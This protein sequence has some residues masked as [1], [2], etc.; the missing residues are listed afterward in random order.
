MAV[1]H[2]K[3][4]IGARWL[5]NC[6]WF[7]FLFEVAASVVA[8]GGGHFKA[9]F[10]ADFEADLAFLQQCVGLMVAR[11]LLLLGMVYLGFKTGQSTESKDANDGALK[12]RLF[13]LQVRVTK[14]RMPFCFRFVSRD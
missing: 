5:S 6:F 4:Q 3:D 11:P 14:N 10:E 9:D 8:A 12:V 2:N 1:S 7:W 13:S